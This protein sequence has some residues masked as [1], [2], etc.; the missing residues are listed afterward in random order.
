MANAIINAAP[1]TN[2]LGVQDNS[3]RALVPTP[4]NLPTHLAKVYLY[5]QTGPGPNQPQ[6][7]VG[8]SATQMFGA[9]TF[10]PLKPYF[11]HQTALV[12]NALNPAANQYMVERVVPTDAAP[13]ANLRIYLDVL[14]TAVPDYVR[15]ADGSIKTDP[16]TGDPIQVT[17]Q[18][19]TLPG[20]QVKWVTQY[21]Q[22][23]EDG[24]SQVGAGTQVV[25]DL[26]DGQGGQSTRYPIMDLQ[27]SHV[28]AAGN[29]NGFRMWAPTSASSTP[30]DDSFITDEGVYPFR[31]AFARKPSDNGTA[32]VVAGNDGS[33]YYDLTFKPNTT[34]VNTT[35]Q[36]YV[37]DRLIQ[38]YQNLNPKAGVV[39]T[40]GP[41]GVL[42]VYDANIAQ[43]VEQFYE[44]EFPHADSFSDF[45]GAANEQWL[46][47]FLS[48]VSSQNVPYHTYQVI[49]AAGNATRFTENTTVYASGGSDGTMNDTDFAT[50]VSAAVAQYADPNSY[51]Q[52]MA[53]YPESIIYD[54]GF[55]LQTK[56]DLCQFISVRKDT[57][58]VLGTHD[59]AAGTVL[60]A[61]AESALAIALRTRLQMYPESDYFGTAT[62]RGMIVGRSGTLIS[63][64]YTKRLPMTLEFAAKAAAY[65]GS[66]D[67]VWKSA[68][69]FDEDPLN[70]V[71]LMTNI[72][73]VFTPASV[74]NTDWDNGLVWVEAYGRGSYYFPAFKT[75]YNNDTSVLT[76]FFTAMG[77]V[78]LEKVGER[79]RKK[80]SGNSKLKQ[81]Q[82]VDRVNKEAIK[83]T[84]QRFDGRF[85]IIPKTYFTD[86]DAARGYSWTLMLQIYANNMPTVQTLIIQANRSSDLQTTTGQQVAT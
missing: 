5:A 67:G 45:T 84:N 19:A 73:V 39:P 57:F 56:Y 37:G 53:T 66:G 85:T 58:V 80:F 25:G 75:V 86:A 62:M 22:P 26:T 69:S 41:F 61:A 7:V 23:D 50:L 32:A 2:F 64:T 65:M 54:T 12:V 83:Q 38:A 81:S 72:N 74:R 16:T 29:W 59:V 30:I 82:L 21:I 51:L 3:T 79:I 43:L 48:G 52:D 20:F 6:L 8:D 14:S 15:N 18:G 9:D 1:M 10:D 34:N 27:V 4:E 11:N 77:C 47:N 42:K 60:T 13:R 78:E 24:N 46:F 49:T 35:Q 70:Q 55:P 71:T 44:A 31:F 17:G 76:S 40:W 63:S 68:N 28:G 36:L 33:Q